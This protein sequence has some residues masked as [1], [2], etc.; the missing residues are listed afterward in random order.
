MADGLRKAIDQ[1]LPHIQRITPFLKNRVTLQLGFVGV[2]LFFLFLSEDRIKFKKRKQ[3]KISISATPT[4]RS[5]SNSSSSQNTNLT[6]AQQTPSI[7]NNN[8][9]NNV[10]KSNENP[11]TPM[12]PSGTPILMG[13]KQESSRSNEIEQSTNTS[14]TINNTSHEQMQP[15]LIQENGIEENNNLVIEDDEEQ[16]YSEGLPQVLLPDAYS[17]NVFIILFYFM[18][19]YFYFHIERCNDFC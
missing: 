4:S 10:N 2:A 9:A 18:L 17:D 19:F 12:S 13:L 11:K 16:N 5:F 15:N 3:H 7:K 1:L 14:S 8:N 6:N